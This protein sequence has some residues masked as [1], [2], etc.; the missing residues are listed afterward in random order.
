L[1]V[2]N[3]SPQM[4]ADSDQ[5]D[6]GPGIWVLSQTLRPLNLHPRSQLAAHLG[7]TVKLFRRHP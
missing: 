4:T 3:V 6:F 2:I 7:T 5:A 1:D